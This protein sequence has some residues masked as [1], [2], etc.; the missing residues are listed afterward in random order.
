MTFIPRLFLCALFFCA[1]SFPVVAQKRF[2]PVPPPSPFKHSGQ[3]VTSFDSSANKMRTTLEHPR[4]LGR[5]ADALYLSATFLH[6]DPRYPTPPTM[7]VIVISTSAVPKYR[8]SHSLVFFCDGRALPLQRLARYQSQSNG[9]GIIYEAT[10]ITLSYED[11]LT[12]TGAKK[13]SARLGQTEFELSG[14]HLEAL[15]E[16][17]SLLAPSPGRWRAEE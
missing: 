14:N 5:G 2:C 1:C 17:V 11:L 12:I 6:Q 7:D 13:V 8:D 3:I 10:R 9:Q 16:L 4:S 15:R